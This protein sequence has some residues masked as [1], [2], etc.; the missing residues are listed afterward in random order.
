[1]RRFWSSGR[2]LLLLLILCCPAL[3]RFTTIGYGFLLLLPLL[4]LLLLLLFLFLLV[5]LVL[6][7]LVVV[8]VVVLVLLLL[9]LLLLFLLTLLL[10]LL[11]TLLTS[12]VLLLRLPL[13]LTLQLLPSLCRLEHVPHPSLIPVVIVQVMELFEIPPDAVV[14]RKVFIDRMVDVFVQRRSLQLT[15]GDYEVPH[16]LIAKA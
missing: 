10:L 1:M 3:S 13:P 14:T 4:L 2:K 9:L 12:I 5:V 8:L 15:L 7:L 11:L 16:R 6:L